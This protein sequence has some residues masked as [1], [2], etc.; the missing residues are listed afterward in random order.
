MTESPQARVR[1]YDLLILAARLGNCE[2]TQLLL[3]SRPDS[4]FDPR[5]A[6]T[7][8]VNQGHESMAQILLKSKVVVSGAD[9][10]SKEMI[11][12]RDKGYERIAQYLLQAADPNRVIRNAGTLLG[13]AA[14]AGNVSDLRLLLKPGSSFMDDGY[15]IAL[16][17][18]AKN[19][20]EEA[21]R[22]LLAWTP[23]INYLRERCT[24]LQDAIFHGHES[25]AQ[26]LL[27][28]GFS[29][30]AETSSGETL[31]L[32]AVTD[33]SERMVRFLLD[34]GIDVNMTDQ[35]GEPAL[36]RAVWTF[37]IWLIRLLLEHGADI[38]AE[39]RLGKTLLLIA[40][41]TQSKEIVQ[42]LLDRGANINMTDQE[43]DIT[44]E[45]APLRRTLLDMSAESGNVSITQLLL[46]H[47]ARKS[48]TT[49][50]GET[51]LHRLVMRDRWEIIELLL[52]ASDDIS[53]STKDGWTP[54]HSAAAL[55]SLNSVQVLLENGATIASQSKLRKTA[56]LLA[57]SQGYQ[58]IVLLLLHK[59]A[60]AH[61]LSEIK[62]RNATEALKNLEV[63]KAI[64]IDALQAY[65]IEL[66]L[67]EWQDKKRLSRMKKEMDE[68]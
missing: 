27:Y 22:V 8:A 38:N 62:A 45:T 24:A 57:A 49:Q 1:K 58:E 3:S 4:N 15:S 37:E 61:E 44:F 35:E 36:C 66:T 46:K 60:N 63:L 19:G 32:R 65:K 13:D 53:V 31:L 34:R 39:T 54:L 9:H 23:N 40:V 2:V 5:S 51:L 42:F 11:S 64:G 68:A 67:R 26:I 10:L 17:I 59:G 18:A 33:K 16:S 56:L 52:E 48:V 28:W 25:V 7:I 12:A 21:V 20:Y 6:L 43:G 29:V 55:G 47:G 50:D 14:G 41:A 30:N